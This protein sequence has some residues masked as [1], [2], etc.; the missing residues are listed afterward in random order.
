MKALFNIRRRP[1]EKQVSFL[2]YTCSGATSLENIFIE[3]GI[4]LRFEEE[5][6]K[7]DF[8]KFP[9]KIDNKYSEYSKTEH[10]IPSQFG[11]PSLVGND[12]F[13]FRNDVSVFFTHNPKFLGK[14][15]KT[16][17]LVRDPR[18][19]LLSLFKIHN[20]LDGEN[21]LHFA[22]KHINLWTAFYNKAID[23]PNCY[24]LRFEDLKLNP[25]ITL[26]NLM[27]FIGIRY[28]N[29]KIINA[30]DNSSFEKTK[31]I[32]SQMIAEYPEIASNF[33]PKR[34]TKSGK[35]YQYK[36]EENQ[37]LH[38]GFD[39]IENNVSNVMEKLGYTLSQKNTN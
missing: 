26:K 2:S 33:F 39:F 21:F 27:I 12:N 31:E 6:F 24:I 1:S 25:I 5:S 38:E 36:L 34:I 23:L 16:F 7:Q 9:R 22:K 19:T 15:E 14:N 4:R 28:E 20:D 35:C 18:D 8:F 13:I 11:L 30:I 32:E 37:I 29:S 10:L 17:I 3:L